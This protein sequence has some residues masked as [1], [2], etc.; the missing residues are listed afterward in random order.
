MKK[1]Y[2]AEYKTLNTMFVSTANTPQGIRRDAVKYLAEEMA[3]DVDF[4][5][6]NS[7]EEIP[8]EWRCGVPWGDNL[9]EE[10]QVTAKEIVEK[11]NIYLDN[12][13]YVDGIKFVMASELLSD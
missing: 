7:V 5:E 3:D 8:E 1:L 6:V 9:V 12:E 4:R 10:K 11:K 13:L 2:F